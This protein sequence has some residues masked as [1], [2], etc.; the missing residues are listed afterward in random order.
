[1][2]ELVTSGGERWRKTCF[3]LTTRRIFAV[4]MAGLDRI[5]RGKLAH[6]RPCLRLVML[7]VGN[8]QTAREM[9]L[10]PVA[11]SMD[12]AWRRCSKGIHSTSGM[13]LRE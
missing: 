6:S 10:A 11:P 5:W 9:P 7:L 3:Q 1:M 12:S 13:A 2:P 4:D 8:M